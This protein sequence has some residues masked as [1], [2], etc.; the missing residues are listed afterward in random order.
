M[1]IRGIPTKA[2]A[3]A[4]RRDFEHTHGAKACIHQTPEGTYTVYVYPQCRT[5]REKVLALA[6]LVRDRSCA[7]LGY[8]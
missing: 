5:E 1:I 7:E 3:M 6:H 4:L 2:K 8:V